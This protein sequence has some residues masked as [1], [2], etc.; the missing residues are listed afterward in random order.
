MA[1][2][3]NREKRVVHWH[4]E[5]KEWPTAMGREKHDPLAQRETGDQLA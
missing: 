1:A 2:D 4:G 5:R 3:W